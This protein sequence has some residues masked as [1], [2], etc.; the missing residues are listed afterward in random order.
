MWV[1]LSRLLED[2][3][4]EA[5]YTPPSPAAMKKK[6]A[7]VRKARKPSKSKLGCDPECMA[8]FKGVSGG[9]KGPDILKT[10]T[11]A[12]A[13]CCDKIK[14]EEAARKLCSII[15]S[16]RKDDEEEEEEEGEGEE[17]GK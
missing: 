1:R 15:L 5:K 10:C 14:D 13:N 9:F 8:D 6:M 16:R 12:F 17:E 7:K 4:I 2:A 11:S 3:V